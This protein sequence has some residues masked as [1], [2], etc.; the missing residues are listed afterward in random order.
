M[1]AV[2]IIFRKTKTNW[3]VDR[4][5]SFKQEKRTSCI[6]LYMNVS[7]SQQNISSGRIGLNILDHNDSLHQQKHVAMFFLLHICCADWFKH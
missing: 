1:I 4:S 3:S 5:L 2:I 6:I 7:V